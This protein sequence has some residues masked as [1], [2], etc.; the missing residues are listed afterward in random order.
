[1]QTSYGHKPSGVRNGLGK[2]ERS[3]VPVARG[4]LSRLVSDRS[5]SKAAKD[6]GYLGVPGSEPA[7]GDERQPGYVGTAMPGL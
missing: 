5:F 2:M 3:V 7:F 1:M 4:R 6:I